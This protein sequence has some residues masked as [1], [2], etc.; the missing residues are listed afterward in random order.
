M[1]NEIVY[2]E[3]SKEDPN[4][5]NLSP[6]QGLTGRNDSDGV[7]FNANI[8]LNPE[9]YINS[10]QN[11]NAGSP[12]KNGVHE[13]KLINGEEPGNLKVLNKIIIKI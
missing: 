9:M 5:H 13:L 8:N 3:Y 10:T 7:Q 4:N 11:R 2:N 12:L 6:N 1:S